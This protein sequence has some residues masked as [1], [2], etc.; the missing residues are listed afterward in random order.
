MLVCI[1]IFILNNV[2]YQRKISKKTVLINTFIKTEVILFDNKEKFLYGDYLAGLIIEKYDIKNLIKKGTAVDILDQNL[3]GLYDNGS[4]IDSV[5]GQIILAGHNN[6]YVFEKLYKLRI[7][8]EI[9]IITREKEYSYFVKELKIIE[10]DDTSYFKDN[11][12]YK[13]L[14]LITCIKNNK[15]R[16]LVI[17]E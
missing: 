12:N 8:D 4:D 6:S 5:N 2:I 15:Y 1:I 10:K 7:D 3:V 11:I 14:I 17:A 9:K 13:E 16:L